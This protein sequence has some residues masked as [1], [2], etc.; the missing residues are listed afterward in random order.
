MTT[1]DRFNG[2][3]WEGINFR[4]T[5]VSKKSPDGWWS[6]VAYSVDASDIGDL[7]NAFMHHDVSKISAADAIRKAEDRRVADLLG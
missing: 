6:A 4:T 1:D 3:A 5:T 2:T 7:T